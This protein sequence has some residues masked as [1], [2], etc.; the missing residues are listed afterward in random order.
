MRNTLDEGLRE[1]ELGYLAPLV[2]RRAARALARPPAPPV[3]STTLPATS[4]WAGVVVW[5]LL[6]SS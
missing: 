5:A 2:T 1:A 3:T 6:G 4:T